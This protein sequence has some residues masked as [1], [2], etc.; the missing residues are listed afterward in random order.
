MEE[1][2]FA[3]TLKGKNIMIEHLQLKNESCEKYIKF[4]EETFDK[5]KKSTDNYIKILESQIFN[6]NNNILNESEYISILKNRVEDLNK[7]YNKLKEDLDNLKKK[8]LV[9]IIE[10]D[11]K[12]LREK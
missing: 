10:K 4:V 8:H 5:H 6:K 3:Q 1:T 7:N 9:M 2:T 12:D 11:L